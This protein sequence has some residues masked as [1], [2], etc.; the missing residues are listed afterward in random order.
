MSSGDGKNGR[1]PMRREMTMMVGCG[2]Q[3]A[4]P[5]MKR[6]ITL[7]GTDPFNF[8]L[9]MTK[10]LIFSLL[11]ITSA[12]AADDKEVVVFQKA[13]P[14]KGTLRITHKKA[15]I[16]GAKPEEKLPSGATR[17]YPDVE[18]TYLISLAPKDGGASTPPWKIKT[19]GRSDFFSGELQFLDAAVDDTDDLIVVYRG[20]IGVSC[21][22]VPRS[23]NE[24]NRGD[25][26]FKESEALGQVAKTAL[27]RGLLSKGDLTVELTLHGGKQMKFWWKDDKWV[28]EVPK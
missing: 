19:R 22:I 20:A 3:F 17:R 26:V 27:I 16:P 10:T 12:L 4:E 2:E 23:E 25:V 5:E 8:K 18:H 13:V 15:A 9:F 11:L 7:C 6:N 14:E 1:E 28:E 24:K 21:S